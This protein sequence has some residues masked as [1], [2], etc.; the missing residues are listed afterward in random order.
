MADDVPNYH[1]KDAAFSYLQ[2]GLVDFGGDTGARRVFANATHFVHDALTS[3]GS[4]RVLI[5]CA[6]GSNRSATVAI[7]VLMGFGLSLAQAWGLVM[8]RRSE[9]R[10]LADNRRELLAF[11]ACQL[12]SGSWPTMLEGVGATL[13]PVE[14]G[15]ASLLLAAADSSVRA[16]GRRVRWRKECANMGGLVWSVARDGEQIEVLQDI[17]AGCTERLISAAAGDLVVPNAGDRRADEA[18]VA[19][20]ALRSC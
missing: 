8:S 3:S 12:P 15:A 9:A 20:A 19:E 17:P 7:A 5:H 6:N 11:E 4:H 1:E 14:V 2:L 10:P 13:V 16:V 18:M